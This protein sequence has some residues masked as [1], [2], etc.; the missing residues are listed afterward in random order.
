M[1]GYAKLALFGLSAAIS[2]NGAIYDLLL[3]TNRNVYTRFR[4]LQ[5]SIA[6][7]DLEWINS[8]FH[9]TISSEMAIFS[10]FM[11][12]YVAN[13]KYVIYGHGYY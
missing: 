2:P 4:L 6:L 5:K 12:K 9:I 3:I 8:R 7:D 1:V 10:L 13:D 11:Q